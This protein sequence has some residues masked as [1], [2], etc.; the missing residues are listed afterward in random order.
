MRQQGARSEVQVGGEAFKDVAQNIGAGKD[1]AAAR[2]LPV[3]ILVLR[4]GAVS[5][6]GR[7]V[8]SFSVVALQ[9]VLETG[10]LGAG[11]VAMRAAVGLLS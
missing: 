1:A 7:A 11:V 6:G 4:R 5:E 2:R 3:V 9:V 8:L 10:G